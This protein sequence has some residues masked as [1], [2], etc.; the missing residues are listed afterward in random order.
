MENTPFGSESG[1]PSIISKYERLETTNDNVYLEVDDFETIA[2]HY[3]ASRN[4]EDALKAIEKGLAQHFYNVALYK[5]KATIFI[6]EAQYK[7]AMEVVRAAYALSPED[8]ILK[9]LEIECIAFM[10][11]EQEA[12]ARLNSMKEHGSEEDT[13][14]ALFV[15]AKV[16][17]R[18]SD[19][20][21]IFETLSEVL[22]ID[23]SNP[24]A[25]EKIWFCVELSGKYEESIALH[26]A[27]IDE[28]PYNYL[29]WY[30]L[31]H[32]YT[33]IDD[34]DNALMAYEYTF[35]INEDFEYGYRDFTEILINKGDFEKALETLEEIRLKFG[36][37]A[38]LYLNLGQCHLHLEDYDE[39]FKYLIK[40]KEYNPLDS[41]IYFLL[42]LCEMAGARYDSAIYYLSIAIEL[43]NL[44][45]EYYEALSSIHML[46][47]DFDEAVQALKQAIDI[48]P[49]QWHFTIELAKLYI[50]LFEYEKA[51]NTLTNVADLL[52]A[53]E[54]RYCLSICHL[55]MGDDAI[56]M[57]MLTQELESSF[58]HH[59]IL[60][61][62]NIPAQYDHLIEDLIAQYQS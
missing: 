60:H 53:P 20:G 40:A 29:A 12:L 38:E 1:K 22:D 55:L 61:E 25:L 35:L 19:F 10:G 39:A 58:E 15:Q 50:E 5:L 34:L 28:Q 23:P 11:N 17:E 9:L 59:Y 49:E 45:E 7:K 24:T 18:M 16:Y 31:G 57:K 2:E 44:K 6:T 32:A 47:G 54:V 42:G 41:K 51:Y 62:L 46:K 37:D 4:H 52:D 26:Q 30:N 13:I 33:C 48:A 43:D 14:D 56:G 21:A 27:I 8:H 36:K 3:M